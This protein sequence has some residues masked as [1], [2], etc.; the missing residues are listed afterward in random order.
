[1]R[2]KIIIFTIAFVFVSCV[3]L[4]MEPERQMY[5]VICVL[6]NLDKHQRLY[7]FKTAPLEEGTL[8]DEKNQ[9]I[10]RYFIERYVVKDAGAE[11]INLG[12][13]FIFKYGIYDSLYYSETS[14]LKILPNQEYKLSINIP[15][16]TQITGVTKTPGKIEIV[17]PSNSE[18]FRLNPG[19][20]RRHVDVVFSW[21]SSNGAYG[22]MVT[23]SPPEINIVGRYHFVQ[24]T[25]VKLRFEFWEGDINNID[26]LKLAVKIYAIDANFYYH[27]IK[28]IDRAGFSNA[29]GVFGSM[30]G[31][32]VTLKFIK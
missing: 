5:N 32:S 24:D 21:R 14:E 26:T 11:L 8:L 28:G 13:R 31:D 29:Y 27:A 10:K 3:N 17:Q 2:F 6:S 19:N 18:I 16:G 20:I 25:I 4:S 1:M 12:N 23:T 7:I 15:D 9:L 30:I 22:Y